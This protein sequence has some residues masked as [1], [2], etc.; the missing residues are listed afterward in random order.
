LD[1]RAVVIALAPLAG[2]ATS[3]AITE[4]CLAKNADRCFGPAYAELNERAMRRLN[5]RLVLTCDGTDHLTPEHI[6]HCMRQLSGAYGEL[7]QR[8]QGL[9]AF[10]PLGPDA[11]K[12]S[13][14]CVEVTS[15]DRETGDRSHT[16]WCWEQ[17]TA[18]IE[19]TW[20]T[21][22]PNNKLQRTRDRSF[23]EQ[24]WVRPER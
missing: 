8:W 20:E 15:K 22:T 24:R 7:S 12:V 4:V 14:P 5:G 18:T 11:I 23:G 3:G 1:H 19:F 6:E 10:Q 17:L 2:C 21:A 13:A 16:G 9:I